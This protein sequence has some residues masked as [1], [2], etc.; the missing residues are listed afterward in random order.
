MICY[1][2]RYTWYSGARILCSEVSF[3]APLT[4]LTTGM[5]VAGNTLC[6]VTVMGA[7]LHYGLLNSGK[8]V[9]ENQTK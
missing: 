9:A 7:M 4:L 3:L 1:N 8:G 5:M 2:L 6:I